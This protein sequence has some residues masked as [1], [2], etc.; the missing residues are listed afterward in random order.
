M[1]FG[2]RALP[3][4]VSLQVEQERPESHDLTL[5]SVFAVDLPSQVFLILSSFSQHS[6][7]GGGA[8]TG[9]F[10]D[11]LCRRRK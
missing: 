10:S 11:P 1:L 8:R 3:W 6:S 5:S 4:N 9:V 7:K 2:L